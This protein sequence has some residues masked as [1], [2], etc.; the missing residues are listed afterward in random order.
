MSAFRRMQIDTYLSPRTE[1]KF[2]CIKDL[3]IKLDILNLLEHKVRNNLG[4]PGTGDSFLNRTLIAQTLRSMIDKWDLMKLKSFCT[5]KDTIN[6]TKQYPTDWERTF[7]NPMSDRGLIPKIYKEP[8]KLDNT[9][10]N[11][12]KT[13]VEIQTEFSQEESQTAEKYVKDY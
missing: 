12:I 8:K 2:K 11:S 9:P 7:T 5:A 10:N 1:L 6:R 4:L 3:S 13:V